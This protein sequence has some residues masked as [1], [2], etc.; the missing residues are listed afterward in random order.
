[1]SPVPLNASERLA[2]FRRT[3]DE[4]FAAPP[5]SGKEEGEDFLCCRVRGDGYALR[6]RELAAVSPAGRVI[7]LPSKTPELLGVAGHRGTLVPVYSL[8]AL[9]GYGPGR[10]SPRW[11]ALVGDRDPLALAL[12]ELEGF[13]RVPRGDLQLP[14]REPGK[15]I[16]QLARIGSTVRAILK[17]ASLVA[18]VKRVP[19]NPPGG[20]GG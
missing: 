7:P 9:L 11:L 4:T 18:V 8:A 14:G 1:M 13:R 20:S 17:V 10:E 12:G 16:D 2:E 3:F 19:A 15:H 6:V 5:P